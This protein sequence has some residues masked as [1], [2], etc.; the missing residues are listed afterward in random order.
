MQSAVEVNHTTKEVQEEETS[1]EVKVVV[2]AGEGRGEFVSTA[3][4]EGKKGRATLA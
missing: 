2:V 4:R 3:W 1:D